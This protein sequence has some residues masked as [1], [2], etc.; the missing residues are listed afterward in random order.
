MPGTAMDSLPADAPAP[1]LCHLSKWPDFD[2][3]GFNLQ[4][5]QFIGKVD[6][7]SPAQH[8]QLREGDRIVEVNGASIANEN[9]RQVVDRIKAVPNQ[10]RLLVLDRAADRYYRELGWQVHGE[11]AN[12]VYCATPRPR[13]ATAG[14]VTVLTNGVGEQVLSTQQVELHV[15]AEGV[16]DSP[17]TD[18]VAEPATVRQPVD[19][20]TIGAQQV[21]FVQEPDQAA[22]LDEA[23]RLAEAQ[24]RLVLEQ[25][26]VVLVN[27]VHDRPEA[28]EVVSVSTGPTA[29]PA[30]PAV[31]PT[32]ISVQSVAVHAETTPAGEH[33]VDAQPAVVVVGPPPDESPAGETTS[34]KPEHVQLLPVE[35]PV[36]RTG[37]RQDSLTIPVDN[38]QTIQALGDA[39]EQLHSLKLVV[40]PEQVSLDFGDLS[41]FFSMPDI[42]LFYFIKVLIRHCHSSSK[43]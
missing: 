37:P 30:E 39:S 27:G 23:Q 43:K 26:K 6:D 34:T 36:Q 14:E 12:V 1:R 38:Q 18:A 35:E 3:F 24:V 32:I 5:G 16:A 29:Q 2:G 8:A 13:P 28:D 4:L 10:T 40:Q 9:H 17:A 11:Q 41:R 25:A 21:L 20:V 42:Y 33:L 22:E 31:E 19:E 15:P 7:D